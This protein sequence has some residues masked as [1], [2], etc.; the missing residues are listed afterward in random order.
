MGVPTHALGSQGAEV[1]VLGLGCMGM[2][3]FYGPSDDA[4]SIAVIHKAI[5]AGIT[6]LDTGDFYGAGHNEELIARAIRGMRDKIFISLKFGP[7]INHDRRLI[8]FDSRPPAIRNFLSYSLQRLKTDY[9]DLYFPSRVDPDV[10]IEDTV[11]TLAELV[12]EGKIRYVGLSEASARTLR[13]AH[14][15][16]PITALQIEYSLFSRDIED[17]VLPVLQELGIGCVAYGVLS[18]SLLSGAVTG[19]DWF[20]AGDF[21]PL[22]PRF[23]GDNLNRNLALVEKLRTFAS[24]RG[25]TPAQAAVAWVLNKGHAITPLVGTR[26]EKYLQEAIA[27]LDVRF[28]AA[29]MQEIETLVPRDSVAGTRYP[30]QHMHQLNG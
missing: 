21:R 30:A 26:R 2:S 5:D 23:A 13:R 19:P 22:M 1:S 3:A 10:P 27:A 20:Q 17:D 18:R 12:K 7:M 15:V 8:G 11:G 9:I 14:E 29:E 28:S 16:F 4:A 6:L 24:A 25:L